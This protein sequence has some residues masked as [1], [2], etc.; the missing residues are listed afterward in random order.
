MD[1][2]RTMQIDEAIEQRAVRAIPLSI[3]K[4]FTEENINSTK[5]KIWKRV[6]AYS[7]DDLTTN[8]YVDSA[9][10]D[11]RVLKDKVFHIGNSHAANGLTYK[12]LACIDPRFWTELVAATPLA[13]GAEVIIEQSA[14]WAFYKFQVKSTVADTPATV[15]AFM[16]GASL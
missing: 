3:E 1:K 15:R 4:R 2:V 14:V 12:L 8:S 11:A 7:L 16:S 10:L 5:P 6:E 13:A 9:I